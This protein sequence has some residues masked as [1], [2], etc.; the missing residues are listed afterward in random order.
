MQNPIQTQIKGD[1]H[2][3][4]LS[5]F[6]YQL[7]NLAAKNP[8]RKSLI[9]LMSFLLVCAFNYELNAQCVSQGLIN[10]PMNG[11]AAA[12]I[13]SGSGLAA[14]TTATFNSGNGV[15]TA[16]GAIFNNATAG[17][18][19]QAT[20]GS[21]GGSASMDFVIN[22]SNMPLYKTFGIYFQTQRTN[23]TFSANLTLT[24]SY[25]KNGGAFQSFTG[26][27]STVTTTYT[28]VTATLPVG[29]DN[30]S[31]SLTIRI[32]A[33]NGALNLASPTWRVDNFQ[34]QA[35][36][37]PVAP[38]T[39]GASICNGGTATLNATVTG[40]PL[41]NWYPVSTGGS[42]LSTSLSYS[43]ANGAPTVPV[44]YSNTTPGNYTFYA[45]ASLLG[46]N[47]TRTPAVINVSTP[48]SVNPVASPA[49]VCSG[50]NSSLNASITNGTAPFNISWSP[51]TYLSS[52]TVANPVITN[53]TATTTYTVSVSDACGNTASATVSLQV[54]NIP[55]VSVTTL[56]VN[57]VI[58]NSGSVVASANGANIYAWT[59]S[60]GLNATNTASVTA[61]PTSTTTY[62]VT[63][64][65]VD[66]C[67]STSSVTINVSPVIGFS[68]ISSP[69]SVC[70]NG[71]VNLSVTAAN[72]NSYA[73]SQIPFGFI[74]QG[75]FTNVSLA[76]DAM[77]GAV[78]LPF[79]FSYYGKNVSQLFICSNGFIQFEASSVSTG[80]N[81]QTL[82]NA[83]NP[84][85]IIAGVWADLDPGAGG[86]I[87]YW[88]SGTAP[89]RVF[90]IQFNAVPFDDVILTSNGNATFQI[91]LYE[92][93]NL[94]DVHVQTVTNALIP[95][96]SVTT[97][98]LKNSTGS[99]FI[100]PPGRYNNG[101]WTIATPEAWRFQPTGG[102]FSYTWTPSTYLSSTVISNPVAQ[103]VASNIIYTVQASDANG[104]THTATINLSTFQASVASINPANASICNG[105]SINLTA[106]D[107][108]SSEYLNNNIVTINDNGI[109]SPYPSNLSVSGIPANAVVRS[110]Q[111]KSISHTF[112]D[113]IDIVLVSPTGQAVTLMSDMGGGTDIV[114]VSYTFKD[115]FPA[116]SD[117][118]QNL[119]GTYSASNDATADNYPAPGPGSVSGNSTLAAF[120][121]NPNGTWKLFVF[122]DASGDAGNI[123][124]GW[125]IEFTYNG[126]FSYAWS[127]ASGLNSTTAS[128]V[129]ASPATN[130]VYSV[131]VTNLS[132]GCNQSLTSN[133]SMLPHAQPY[134]LEGDSSLCSNHSGIFMHVKD[135]GIFSWGFPSGTI[136]NFFGA[137]AVLY[138]TGFD[139]VF[140]NASNTDAFYVQVVLP[141]AYNSCSSFSDTSYISFN[142]EQAPQLVMHSD[143]VDCF[144][145]SSGRAIAEI[146]FG[147][148][149]RYRWQWYNQFNVLLRDVTNTYTADTLSNVP[150][151]IYTIV[152]TD[153]QDSLTNPYC[154]VIDSVIVGQPAGPLSSFEN[155]INH[156]DVLCH[157][158]STGALDIEVTGGTAPY[159]YLWSNGASLQDISNLPAGT[160]TCAISDARNCSST[161]NLSITEPSAISLNATL[162]HVLCNGGITGAIDVTVIGGT[163][164]YTYNWSNGS[165]V[166]LN[167]GIVAGV[168][169]LTVTDAN[170]CTISDT[171]SITEPPLLQVNCSSTPN[172]CF[173]SDN[174]TLNVSVT[175]GSPAYSYLW[176][177]S[178]STSTLSGLSDGTYTVTVTDSHGCSLSCS[179]I[180]TEPALLYATYSKTD[181]LCNGF[182]TGSIDLAI[183]G[184]T[185]PYN[186]NW[187]SGHST[188]D[189]ASLPAGLYTCTITDNNGCSALVD[190]TILE[191]AALQLNETIT[192]VLCFGGTGA[193]DVIVNGG[194]APY[195]YNW[196]GGS[197]TNPVSGL[198]AGNYTLIVT[199]GNNCMATETYTINQPP[200]LLLSCLTTDN[201]CYKSDNGSISALSTGGVPPYNYLWS[202]GSTDATIN[203]LPVGNYEVTMTDDNGCTVSQSVT[204][205]EPSNLTLALLSTVNPTSAAP[206]GGSIDIAAVGGTAPYTYNWSNGST[207][208]NI[209]ALSV[210][211]YT[212]VVTDAHGCTTTLVHTINLICTLGY[213][214]QVV[215]LPSCGFNNGIATVVAT[216]G[217]SYS[218]AWQTIPVQT[219][220]TATGL[221]HNYSSIV[222]IS[223]ISGCSI[224]DTLVLP[225]STGLILTLSSPVYAGGYNIR[226]RGGNDGSINLS[227]GGSTGPFTYN[228][229][230]GATT[231]NLTGLSSGTYIV[232]VSNGGCTNSNLITLTQPPLLN[233]TVTKTNLNCFGN[234]SGTAS[235]V[236][237]GGVPPYAYSW[238][239][240]PVSTTA[241]VTG[242]AAGVYTV[243][244]SDANGCT[245]TGSV[246]L[247]QPAALVVTG[248]ITNVNCF[249]GTN[250]SINISLS[251]G[252]PPF[253]YLW[254]G[255]ATTKDRINVLAAGNY[256]VT[257]TDSKGCTSQFS[258][259]VTQPT[260]IVATYT[261]TNVSCFGGTNGTASVS[262]S[263]GT[264]GYSYSWNTAPP[265]ST[266]SVIGLKKGNY[267]VTITDSKGCLKGVNISI[268][269]PVAI[270]IAIAKT[271]VTVP[272]GNN[273]TA[274]ANV[275]GGVSPF[276]YLWNTVPPKTTKTITGLTAGIYTVT[277]TDINGCTKS[278]S[279]TITQPGPK[280]VLTTYTNDLDVLIN[281]NPTIGR[282]KLTLNCIDCPVAN[283]ILYNSIGLKLM[284]FKSSE[285]ENYF[286]LDRYGKG[287][288]YFDITAGEKRKT[289]RVVVQ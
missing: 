75:T 48:V 173:N 135:A 49:A 284:E 28:G 87:R 207:T 288:Y 254:T 222:I 239:T 109:A 13:T 256:M 35:L 120:S 83:A 114:N 33:T 227:V 184:G 103:N 119:T 27:T 257:V 279:V 249:G 259:T 43:P 78:S 127:P 18:S 73:V 21:F 130:T 264:P 15:A 44:A 252:S 198:L 79:S 58:C 41:F 182:N 122:D 203:S 36:P 285:P 100:A 183:N 180:I 110:V 157:G 126:A 54:N 29:A 89:N 129:I 151:G 283:I 23:P 3:Q 22:G 12:T 116:M 101:N 201:S 25:S 189:L 72:T 202:T 223:D 179:A 258:G 96:A 76:N 230:N 134:L 24:F 124:G 131:L 94:I 261:S 63:G 39:T 278:A 102:L 14:S 106:S 52:T 260:A 165:T 50:V 237:S 26:S 162:S 128:T 152:I 112:P 262:V 241:N 234:N 80:V 193:I 186:Y 220:A 277:V 150:A 192:H 11:N 265:K 67:T 219:T 168:Y 282:V 121:G 153:H 5:N 32:T 1:A 245:K 117:G 236:A 225:T 53:P 190:V 271:N 238:N 66:G 160:Y 205:N 125:S 172:T 214:N 139:S 281:P 213:T 188:E 118:N 273:G 145:N 176:S 142:S 158:N 228:W 200:Q 251:G 4:A 98:A 226:C 263:G 233:A 65:S 138:Q 37:S 267:T 70:T 8:I 235:V 104:C 287:L 31:T 7:K 2:I 164:P 166:Q 147:G 216:G 51:A 167:N 86:T 231:Q 159:T 276:S 136:F 90:V 9:L 221:S 210:G 60:I 6:N 155:T 113:D 240:V 244:V 246:S 30:P 253:N 250:G 177:N 62:T 154:Q 20:V 247:T 212:V 47:S 146:I 144:S 141:A 45:Q 132:T 242:L 229:S 266:A 270:A 169:T 178:E 171:Y 275:S 77:S 185:Q 196:S 111:L 274:T 17:G 149:P 69:V 217:T 195:A 175:G 224:I 174:G 133:L 55:A 156:T 105:T 40:N 81:G 199:D 91:Q 42:S 148:T 206:N 107:T 181:V 84:N 289:I 161:I 243:T 255:G 10:F 232:T 57:G 191:P 209:S 56:P 215:Q 93:S 194:V 204:I 99:S 137:G 272:G 61:S 211:T 108:T 16:A 64:T 143:S 46:C 280:Q 170:G 163:G 286:E 123:A 97:L 140:F 71:S 187:S 74:A 269:E 208:Q 38:T 115:G 68:Q 268:T 59:P 82:P 19:V 88:T 92:S 248:V 34:V 218:Y 197:S 95:I 85:N